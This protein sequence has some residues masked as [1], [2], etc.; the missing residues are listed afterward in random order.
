MTLAGRSHEVWLTSFYAA[1]P[2]DPGVA[3]ALMRAEIRSLKVTGRP[4]VVFAAPGSAGEAMLRAND[5][6][7]LKRNTLAVARVHGGVVGAGPGGVAA[8]EATPAD[9]PVLAGLVA[10]DCGGG[11]IAD[12]P[13]PAT[14]AHDLGDPLG[15]CWAVVRGPGGGAV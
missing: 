4:S 1:V 11:A 14:L 3:L 6:A 12:R 8:E 7:G 9:G 2:G 15:R 10:R 13:D 5:A